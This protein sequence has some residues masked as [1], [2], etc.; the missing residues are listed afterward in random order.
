MLLQLQNIKSFER[1]VINIVT[2][3][4]YL[5]F[6]ILYFK[7]QIQKYELIDLGQQYQI[8]LL[9]KPTQHYN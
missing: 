6:F 8:F 5:Y 2:I 9:I 7:C 4:E 1:K 3:I